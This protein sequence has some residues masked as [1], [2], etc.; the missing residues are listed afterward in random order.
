VGPRYSN[1]PA[2]TAPPDDQWAENPYT[3][4]GDPPSYSFDFSSSI[5][6]GLPI[7]KI[8]SPSHDV[9]VNFNGETEARVELASSES[10]GGNRDLILRYRLSSETIT[11]GLLLHEG[12]DENFFLMMLQP[13][14]RVKS[15][16]VPPREYLFVMDMSGSMRGFPLGVSKQLLRDLIKPLRPQDRFNVLLFAVGSANRI[17]IFRRKK[18]CRTLSVLFLRVKINSERNPTM[19]ILR[20]LSLLVVLV[21]WTLPVA[22][23]DSSSGEPQKPQPPPPPAPVDTLAAMPTGNATTSADRK[24]PT[25]LPNNE[26]GME[27]LSAC[28]SYP[29]EALEAGVEGR[30]TVQFVVDEQGR[31]M[32]PEVLGAK[33][34]HGLDEEALRCAKKL[35]FE[36]GKEN[37]KP[38][39]VQFTLP[40]QF[41]GKER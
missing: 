7:R 27:K 32:N 39:K 1:Q 2:A 40:V 3:K 20:R 17:T 6:A 12:E 11:P 41:H 29:E 38:V 31:V 33:L 13:P 18:L 36:P 5:A 9:D 25:L 26:K 22:A 23:Q 34:G 10:D 24:M 37:G 30:V 16:E 8:A 15:K 21:F 19:V 14:E 28:T 35:R 4:A